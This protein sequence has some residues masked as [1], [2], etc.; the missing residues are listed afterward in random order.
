MR[1]P[2]PFLNSGVLLGSREAVGA[3]LQRFPWIAKTDDQAYWMNAYLESLENPELPR[4]EIDH[5]G[6]LACCFFRQPLADLACRNGVIYYREQ[7]T[8][9]CLLHFN[10]PT[11]KIM[12]QIASQIG[13]N[14]A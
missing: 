13:V 12:P 5:F 4:I 6:I 11:K 7:G 2:L 14:L 8:R 1:K 9:P 3:V 10:G